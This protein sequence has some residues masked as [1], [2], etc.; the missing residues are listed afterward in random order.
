MIPEGTS[1][2]SKY[3]KMGA[4]KVQTGAPGTYIDLVMFTWEG[5]WHFDWNYVRELFSKSFMKTLANQYALMLEQLA[6]TKDDCK[7]VRIY[8]NKYNTRAI[9][10]IV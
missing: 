8:R 4:P 6:Q 3:F 10:P 9:Q 2:F 7:T 1:K 5:E